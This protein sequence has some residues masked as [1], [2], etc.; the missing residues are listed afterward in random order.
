MTR[1]VSARVRTAWL[2]AIVI[3][4]FAIRLF[5]T[6]RFEGMGSGPNS[7]AFYDGVEF[8]QIAANIVRHGEFSVRE[9]QPTSFR[10]PGLPFVLAGVYALFGTGNFVAAHILFCLIGAATCVAAY[11]VARE[12]AGEVGGLVT[13]ALVAAYPNILYY[14]IHFSSE[15]LFTV[16]LL[17]AVWQFI[18]GLRSERL[19]HYA[20]SGV[21]LGLSALTRPASFYFLPFFA[22]VAVAVER[23]RW[24]A[25]IGRVVLMAVG[26]LIPIAPWAIRNYGVHGRTVLLASNGG[27][28]FWG[29]NNAIVLDDPRY[30]GDWITTEA[31]GDQKR[32]VHAVPNEVDRDRLE[33]DFGKEFVRQHLADVPRLLWYKLYWLWTPA[34][35]TPNAEFNRIHFL[36]YGA[37]LPFII[38]GFILLLRQRGLRDEALLAIVAPVIATTAATLV[39]YGSARFRSTI[40]PFLLIFA[41]VALLALVSRVVGRRATATGG[42]E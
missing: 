25:R 40:E 8:E 28:T 41:S 18:R 13:A 34:S 22:L 31:M 21:L 10:A 29:A 38:A 2:I 27:S 20:M 4:A 19:V 11:L 6:V 24:R 33:W 17:L 15:P 32:L 12:V 23:A 30:H 5:A 39:F 7:G 16:L 37:A 1:P 35:R 9:G 42:A 14:A 3:A 26:L 36:S